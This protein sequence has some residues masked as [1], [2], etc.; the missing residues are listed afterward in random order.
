MDSECFSLTSLEED[1]LSGKSLALTDVSAWLINSVKEDVSFLM[2]VF[3]VSGVQLDS[4]QK[5]D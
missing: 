3:K 5:V 2:V 1:H 4:G